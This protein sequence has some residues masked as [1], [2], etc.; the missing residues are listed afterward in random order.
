MTG[1]NGQLGR[2][3][4]AELGAAS[5]IDYATRDDL[6]LASPDLVAA[7]HWR[8]YDTIIN[9]AA[10]TAVDQAQ[11]PEGRRD[12][13]AVNVAGVAELARIATGHG[14][15]LVQVSSDY[16]FDGALTRPYR[17]DNPVSPL[18][19][20]G[21]TK[22]AADAIVATVPRHYI[23]RTS[24]VVGDGAN[25]V[26]TMAGLAARGVDP[27]VV[28]DQVGRLTF[29]S[30]L[31]RGIRHLLD[32]RPDH[33]IYNLTGGG[34]PT[35]WADVA[36]T[37]FEL[38]GHDPARVSPVSTAEYFAGANAPV[39]PRPRNSVLDLG[40]IEATGFTARTVDET[41]REYLGT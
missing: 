31:A 14:I 28:D 33:G 25:F 39:A 12:A 8:D 19:V 11:T 35:T 13:W 27:R 21:Q 24:W 41:L 23:V 30:E 38:T 40:K 3:L 4:R 2:A 26:R 29:T 18:G 32:T 22:A 20:Y 7:R 37:V 6:D 9:A 34:P 10:Y 36:R 1:A 16:V 5:H 17:E 15:T